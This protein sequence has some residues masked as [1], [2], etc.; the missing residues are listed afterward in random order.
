MVAKDRAAL[1]T[2]STVATR[3]TIG[4]GGICW[5]GC[6]VGGGEAKTDKMARKIKNLVPNGFREWEKL[7]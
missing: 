4:G 2:Q 3:R 5:R 6:L 1:R 7:C